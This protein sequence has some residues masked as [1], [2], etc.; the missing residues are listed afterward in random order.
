MGLWETLQALSDRA[1]VAI[2]RIETEE[3]TKTAL[4]MPFL[5]ALGYDVFNPAEVVPEFTADVGIKKGEKVDYAVCRDGEPAILVECKPHGAKLDHYSG[6]LYR[7]FSVTR[8]RIAILTDGLVYRIYSDL[9]EPNKLDEQP[10]LT[11]SLADLKRDAVAQLEGISRQNFDLDKVLQSAEDLRYRDQLTRQFVKQ[12]ESPS[13]EFVRVL[14]DGVYNGRFTAAA[15]DKFRD[16]VRAAMRSHITDAVDR[17]LRQALEQNKQELAERQ[18]V[19]SEAESDTEASDIVT[20]AEELQGLYIVKAIVGDKVDAR[21]VH[22]RDVRSYF[23]VLLDDSNRKPICRL[24]FNGK[25]KYLGV[26]DAEKRE[27]RIKVDSPEDLF[28]H[29]VAIRASLDHVVTG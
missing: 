27:T 5:Q 14:A 26:F 10:F 8:A 7:Y 2:A 29:A 22:G 21:R 1:V 28:T 4:V 17:R 6:Q 25:T 19:Q 20:T 3:A 23:G 15:M 18:E 16:L 13:D 9:H 12:L 24:W 11:V